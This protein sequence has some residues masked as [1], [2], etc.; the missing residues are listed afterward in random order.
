MMPGLVIPFL[1]MERLSCDVFGGMG[2]RD[3]SCFKILAR[4]TNHDSSWCFLGPYSTGPNSDFMQARRGSYPSWSSILSARSVLEKGV[5]RSVS[6]GEK[7]DVWN[8][9][10][11]STLPGSKLMYSK[12]QGWSPDSLSNM[13]CGS[14]KVFLGPPRGACYRSSYSHCPIFGLT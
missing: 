11:V 6:T 14:L 12:P 3:L 4:R 10:G 2:F 13:E 9:K 7:R 8:E 1:S 5:Y